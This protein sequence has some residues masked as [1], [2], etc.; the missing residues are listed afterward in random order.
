MHYFQGS[1]EHRPPGG[2]ANDRMRGSILFLNNP[3][4]T[5]P[6]LKGDFSKK[7]GILTKEKLVLMYESLK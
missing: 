5:S 4:K 6:F 7:Y 2:L 3:H 1:R